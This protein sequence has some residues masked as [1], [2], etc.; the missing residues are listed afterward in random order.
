MDKSSSML[1]TV[2]VCF[3]YVVYSSDQQPAVNFIAVHPSWRNSDTVSPGT[4]D[5]CHG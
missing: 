1:K 2:D 3:K 5:K 4:P